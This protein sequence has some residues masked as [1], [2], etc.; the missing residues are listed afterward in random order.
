M[1]LDEIYRRDLNLLIAL[2]VLL[3]EGS[4][5]GAAKRL[6]MSQSAMSRVLGRLRE[7]LDDPL[8]IRQGQKLVPTERALGLDQDLQQPLEALRM[9]LAPQDFQPKA[10]EQRFVIAATDYAVQT[11]LPYALPE[12]YRQAPAIELEFAPVQHEHLLDQL[13]S[14]GCD[15]A[16]CRTDGDIAPLHSAHLGQV[17]VFCLL[18]KSHPLAD[19]PLTINDYLNYPHAMIAISDGVKALIDAGLR[20][21]PAPKQVLRAYHLETALAVV[22]TMPL[23]IT[24]PADLAYL[25]A[26]KHDLVIRS[27]PFELKP[28]DYSLL[29]HPRCEHS[30]PQRWLRDLLKQEC[31]RL[32]DQRIQDM[33]LG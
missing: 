31:G 24:V 1:E 29:W 26:E 32:I 7:L 9:L 18:S 28:F 14:G 19:K 12:L 27:L 2:K 15:M 11:I 16:I 30:A 17:G 33:G 23:I 13:T 4:V 20:G 22:D 21:H 3:E 6:N 10:C 5:S 8:F 25:V